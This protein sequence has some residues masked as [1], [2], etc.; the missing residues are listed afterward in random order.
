MKRTSCN[1]I[2]VALAC[3]A[4]GCQNAQGDNTAPRVEAPPD[5][6]SEFR[7]L[8][9]Q[10]LES[11]AELLEQLRGTSGG[12][13]GARRQLAKT[14]QAAGFAG[15][16]RFLDNTLRLQAGEPLITTPVQTLIGFAVLE[17]DVDGS[18]LA[19][20]RAAHSQLLALDYDAAIGLLED[21][22]Q[23]Y[24]PSQ[25]TVVQWS[26]AILRKAMATPDR[27]RSEKL[28]VALRLLLTSLEEKVLRA[29]GID[30]RETGY[31]LLA[32]VCYRLEDYASARTAAMLALDGLAVQ[33]DS[34]AWDKA[35]R[36]RLEG[37]LEALESTGRTD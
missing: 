20:A 2:A 18:A 35:S 17:R 32:T 4:C 22:I 21:D 25:R 26:E 30:R 1:L 13:G 6:P 29:E 19:V 27:V 8:G 5:P 9:L 34:P 28:E 15:A 36:E 7:T 31:E 14:Y 33:E 37:L 23:W 11:A 3:L 16:A 24:G 10:P 12:E